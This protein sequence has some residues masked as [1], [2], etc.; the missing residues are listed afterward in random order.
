MD[1][2]IKG[3]TKGYV[4]YQLF[5]MKFMAIKY[6]QHQMDAFKNVSQV[7]TQ[8]LTT[9]MNVILIMEQQININRRTAN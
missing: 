4:K 6:H 3:T 8:F 7:E 9:F 5:T 2:E 1:L